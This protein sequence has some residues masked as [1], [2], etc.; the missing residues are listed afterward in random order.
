MSAIE[1]LPPAE[2]RTSERL[3]PAHNIHVTIGRGSG[4]V[5][6]ISSTGMRVRHS[7]AAMR[8]SQ[9]RV[10]FEW[11]K[12]RFDAT[13]VVLAS[14]VVSLG[15]TTLFET[16]LRFTNMRESSC[17]LLDRILTAMRSEELRRWV[18]NLHGWTDSAPQ[19]EETD[20]GAFL[21]CRLIGMR[22]RTTWTQDSTQPD[23][24]FAVPATIKPQELERLCTT[25][26]EADAE[27]RYLIRLM[28]EETCVSGSSSPESAARPG[29][30]Q[31]A[32]P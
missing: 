20:D 17:E 5:V 29:R 21:R 31:T 27:G 2:R 14:R 4:F 11:E 16:R 7:A 32:A 19:E 24:G 28:A 26:R 3:S 6:D 18:A 15:Y 13:A 12:E 23:N 30:I 9:L 8:G 25:F 22:W 1:A 10:T